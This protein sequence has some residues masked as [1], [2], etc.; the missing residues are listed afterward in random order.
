MPYKARVFSQAFELGL[1]ET[2]DLN[3]AYSTTIYNSFPNWGF[4][5]SIID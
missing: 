2:K 1:P 3:V 5:T 4:T